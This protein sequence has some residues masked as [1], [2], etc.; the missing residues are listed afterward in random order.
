MPD[1][2]VFTIFGSTG[3]LSRTKLLP[4]L[5][6]LDKAGRL[7]EAMSI[8]GIG[9]RDWDNSR[10]RTEV[11]KWL[12]ERL[13]N[14]LEQEAFGRF[15]KR[16]HFLS[17]DIGDA[18]SSAHLRQALDTGP[19]FPPNHVYYLSLPPSEYKVA[20]DYLALAGLNQEIA[21]WRRLV[22]EKPFGYHLEDAQVLD[23]CLHRNFAEHQIFRIDH[24]LGKETVQNVFVFRFA[25]L[26]WEPLWNR[27]LIDHVQITHGE[28][29][30]IEDRAAYY[31]TAGALRDMIQSHLMQMLALVAMEPPASM[32][33]ESI[34]DEKVKVLKSIRPI[35]KGAVHA[36]A[37]RAQYAR[38][39]IKDREVPGYLDEKQVDKQST[40]ETYAALKL[41]IDNWRWRNVPFYLRTGKRLARNSSLIAIRF[42]HP[43]QQLFRETQIQAPPPNWLLMG[44]QPEQCIRAEVQVREPGIG[45]RAR[46]TQLDASTCY[47]AGY[48]LDAYESLLL[49]IISGDH[50]QFL[51]SD[52]VEWAWRVVDPIIRAWSVDRAFIHTYP[53]GSWGPEEADRIFEREDQ[54][55]RHSFSVGDAPS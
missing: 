43:P 12:G 49:D 34:R 44:I 14:S 27:N 28:I 31:E 35:A 30:G 26:M 18:G 9:R 23:H 6:R 38:G 24:Y 48:Q 36:H 29:A 2:C 19:G 52:E 50:S 8:L 45:M 32:D 10:W 21:G 5:Y 41:Y 55:W 3:H 40:T 33:A 7:P 47:Q 54:K 16:L 25:N 53:A 13:G 4:A 17:A 42:K 46:T 51:R 1:A 11:S 15:S 39:R 37:F 20:A 22:V